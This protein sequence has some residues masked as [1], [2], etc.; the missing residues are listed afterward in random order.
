MANR[1]KEKCNELKGIRKK[2]ADKLG[3][4]LHQR[5]CSFEGECKGT[6]PK[7]AQEENILKKALLSGAVALSAVAL[8]ACGS[9]ENSSE[10]TMTTKERIEQR[11]KECNIDTEKLNKNNKKPIT[12]EDDPISGDVEIDPSY[13]NGGADIEGEIEYDPFYGND[14]EYDDIE[15]D[16]A[17]PIDGEE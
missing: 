17:Y 7:C 12:G 2:L 9:S 6:C 4:D 11:K 14:G 3:I 15:G 10:P 8:T 16:V 1:H 13:Y 5:E